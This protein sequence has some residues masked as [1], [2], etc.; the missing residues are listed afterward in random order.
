MHDTPAS[1][2][3]LVALDVATLADALLLVEQLGGL[4]CGFKVGLELCQSEGVPQVV[5]ALAVAAPNSHLF[6]DLKLH[7]IPNTVAAT[8]RAIIRRW[9]GSVAMLTLHCQGGAAMLQAAADVVRQERER[10]G[11]SQPL[12][13]GV[14]VLTSLDAA[15]LRDDLGIGEPLAAYV[16]RLARLAQQ[17]GLDGVVASPHEVAAIRQACGNDLVIV[18]PGVRPHWSACGDQKRTL[19][20]AQALATAPIIW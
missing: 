16:V 19:T 20:P 3:I 8:L 10:M 18:T 4:G 11:L 15:A 9:G 14:T 17:S 6:L 13:L 1:R 5:A 7:D 12:L 2:R